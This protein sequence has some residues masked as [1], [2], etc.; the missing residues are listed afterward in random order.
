MAP[1]PR[2]IQ[3]LDGDVEKATSDTYVPKAGDVGGTLTAT[4]MYDDGHSSE[5]LAKKTAVGPATVAVEVDTRNKPPAFVDQDADMDGVQNTTAERKV[6]ENTEALATDDAVADDDAADNVGSAVTANDPDPNTDPLVYTLSGADAVLFRVRDNGQIEVASG[7]ELDYEDRSSYEVTLTVEDSFVASASIMVTIMVTDVDEAPVMTGGAAIEYAEN[8]TGPVA[9]YTA[10]DPEM[11][12]IVSWSLGGT[13]A[14]A[15]DISNGVLTFKKSPD[16][17]MPADVASTTDD[18]TAAVDDNMYEV[19]VQA[20]DSTMKTGMKTVMVEVADVDEMGM[21]TLSARRP[22]REVALTANLTDPDGGPTGITW[23]WAK[24]MEMDGTFVDIEGADSATYT[25]VDTDRNH[26]LRATAMYTDGEGSGKSAMTMSDYSV[27]GI[28]A[29]NSAPD[30]TGQDEDDQ[31]TGIQVTRSVAENT[32]AGQSVGAPVRGTDGNNDILTY[33]LSGS[34]DDDDLFDINWGTGQIMTKS[35]LNLE[36]GLT[37]RDV[38]TEGMQLRV[39]VRATDPSGDPAAASVVDTNGAEVQVLITVTDVNE[40]P[41]F[42]AGR[43]T[44]SIEE[45]TSTLSDNTYV[46]S[47]PDVGDT[48]SPTWSLSGPDRSKFGITGGQLTFMTDFTPDYEMSVDADM[49]NV[50]EVTVVATVAGMFGSMSGTRDVRVTVENV[51]EAGTVTLNRKPPR[52]GLPVTATLTDPDGSVSGLTWQWG[53]NGATA[54]PDPTPNG[55]IERATSDTYVPKAGDVGGTLTATAMYDDGHSSEG[56]I[57]RT[58]ELAA[59]PVEVDT[60]NKPPAF[61]DQDA[62]MDGVQNTTAERKVDENTGALATDDAVADDDAADNV[63]SA[64][65]A[66]DLDPNTEPLI[67]TLS[68]ADAGL[69]RVRGNGQIEVASGTELNYENRNSYEVTLTAEDS[70]GASASIAVTIMVTDMDEAPEIMRAPD[71]N[72]APE[73][74]SA[75]TSRTVAENMAA[76]EDIGNPVAANDANG[77]TLAYTLG[78][79]DVASFA[80]DSATGQLS[81]KAALDYETK[82]SYSVTVTASDPGDLSD[83]I[84]VTITVTDVDDAEAGDPLLAVYD[85][86]K[87]G[88]IQL[89]EAR[90]AVGDYFGPPR[91]EKL[92]LADTRTVVGLYFAYKN[93]Q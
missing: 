56:S 86:D 82:A 55:D 22:Q 45:N 58:A 87:D 4:A 12:E 93:R 46:A 17:E 7:T 15:F 35:D 51:D 71:A 20:T 6:D 2:L 74:A 8:G 42:S 27:R 37:D 40:P 38:V 91:G 18:S 77:D 32:A 24:S 29:S 63:G 1:P 36:D 68:G 66:N 80:I 88:W 43:E 57:K 78:G 53:I 25:P 3:R 19:T 89:V 70:F 5:G 30:F 92:S 26:Y 31:T 84:D 54:S 28:P 52:V 65:T 67:Y 73:F 44:Y 59:V 48:A 11:T 62:D 33:T 23:Q 76:G 75:M 21:V 16:Y 47:D 79:A 60:R 85:S 39:T 41:A 83:S 14:G 50:Y 69:F 72:V 49:D 13:D 81:T 64:V 10:A 90:V 34:N 9:T 61:V